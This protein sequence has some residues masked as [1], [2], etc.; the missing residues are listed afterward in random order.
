GPP[1]VIGPDHQLPA[2]VPAR[3]WPLRAL[4]LTLLVAALAVAVALIARGRSKARGAAPPPTAVTVTT[5]T[6]KTGDIAVRLESI[7][8]VTPVHTASVTSQVSGMVVAVF[9]QEGQR[10]EKGDALIDID[11]RPYRATLLQ[12]QGA[13]ER[14]E[15]L[16]AQAKMDLERYRAAWARNAIAKQTLD[17]QEKLVLQYGGTVKNDRGAVKYNEVQVEFCHIKAPLAGRVGLRLVDPGNVVQANGTA[18]LAV[19]TQV[20]PMTVVFTISEDNLTAVRDRLRQGA[21]LPVDALDRAAQRR[22]ASGELLTIDNVIDTTTGTV[23]ARA[24]FDNKDDALFPNQFVNVRLVVDTHT[25][26]TL[27]PSSAIQ[28]NGP[29]SFVY[30]I[31]DGVARV[32][33]VKP[34]VTDQGLTQVDGVSAGDVVA[35]SGFDRLR[36][37]ARVVVSSAPPAPSSSGGAGP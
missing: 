9:F 28:Q 8:T 30:V 20:E 32:Q 18:V 6:A 7:G 4:L 23:K 22:L 13:L 15:H 3:S 12:A 21:R 11:A 31:R 2:H 17:D 36:D 24:I 33:T 10:V 14:D 27:I 26:V 35:A 5:A 16:L 25:G 19:V 29:Q 37:G 1:P 34:T